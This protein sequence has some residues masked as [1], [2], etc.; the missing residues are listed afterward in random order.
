MANAII[1]TPEEQARILACYHLL[2]QLWQ[3]QK[4]DELAPS[5]T[6]LP[7]RDDIEDCVIQGW[8][9]FYEAKG[10]TDKARLLLTP[11][12]RDMYQ[13]MNEAIEADAKM[14]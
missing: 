4:D 5:F 7:L 1:H 11:E 8:V 2:R 13:K 12:G 10:K 9:R 14:N 6:D 3:F